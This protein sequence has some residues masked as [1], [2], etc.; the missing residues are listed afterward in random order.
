MATTSP[1][2]NAAGWN[3]HD[4][5]VTLSAS[6][7]DGTSDVSQI[8]YS[9]IGAEP[10]PQTNARGNS[11]TVTISG[12]GITRLTYFATDLAGNAETPHTLTVRLD[13]TPPVV[14]ATPSRP[15]DSV[16]WYNHPFTVGW[17][18]FDG[19]S[20]V[21]SCS[22]P[23]GYGGPDTPA[24]EVA[25]GCTDTAGNTATLRFPFRYDSTPP[26]VTCVPKP[27]ILWPP[28]HKLAPVTTTVI[29]SDPL[30]GA[31]GFVLTRITMSEGNPLT[32]VVGWTV[33]TSS[34]SGMLRAERLGTAPE[35]R[36]YTLTYLGTDAAGN[37]TTCSA[38]VTVP[39]DLRR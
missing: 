22:T 3:N 6:D 20:G 24:A 16:G 32:D 29:V 23:V 27:A 39:H 30:S 31:A 21:D 14:T 11:A 26:T 13:K 25:G 34:T 18:G 12:E 35:G 7:P 15:P 19:V 2:A 38:T 33:G 36:V 5:T 28:D 1:L 37:T 9:A 17:S 4:V 10:I 8:T